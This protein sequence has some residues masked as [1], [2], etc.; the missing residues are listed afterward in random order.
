[1]SGLVLG[2]ACSAD[3]PSRK[4]TVQF[5]TCSGDCPPDDEGGG[6]GDDPAD[7]PVPEGVTCAAFMIRDVRLD[8]ATE[9]D[10]R[11]WEPV[12]LLNPDA[13]NINLLDIQPGTYDRLRLTIEPQEGFMPGP[14]GRKV[15]TILCITIDG[16]NVEY[17]DDTYDTFELRPEGGIEVVPN[18]LSHFLVTFDLDAWFD[19]ID[20]SNLEP[21]DTGVVHINERTNHDLQN[22]IRDRIKD[23]VD[24]VRD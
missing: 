21:D 7:P 12:D 10:Q 20:V 2:T 18:Q 5:A 9:F 6:G 4:L 1:M 8:G 17:R 14:T 24:A 19:G 15:S 22:Q 3:S 16:K 13:S 11:V 23:S